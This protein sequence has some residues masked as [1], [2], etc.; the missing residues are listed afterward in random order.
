MKHLFRLLCLCLLTGLVFA[1][2]EKP[3]VSE[4]VGDESGVVNGD[5]QVRFRVAQIEQI[6]FGD[7]AEGTRATAIGELCQRISFG[8]YQN[9]KV[10]KTVHEKIG[11]EN[12]GQVTL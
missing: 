11:D 4:E 10:L 9:G 8:I 7:S 6:P 12:F 2:C 1:S 3:S 5:I